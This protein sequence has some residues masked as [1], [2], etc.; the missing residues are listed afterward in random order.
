MWISRGSK[1]QTQPNNRKIGNIRG[2]KRSQKPLPKIRPNQT[3]GYT[4]LT[5]YRNSRTHSGPVSE[6]LFEVKYYWSKRFGS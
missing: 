3:G 6:K 2:T 4:V 1:P 5:N